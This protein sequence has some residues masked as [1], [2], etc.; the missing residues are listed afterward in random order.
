VSNVWQIRR[1]VL[2]DQLEELAGQLRSKELIAQ[3]L[4]MVLWQL[5]EDQQF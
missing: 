3:P 5:F 1:C 4:D 2:L